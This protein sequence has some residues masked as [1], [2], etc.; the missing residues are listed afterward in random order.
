MVAGSGVGDQVKDISKNFGDFQKLESVLSPLRS[1][2]SFGKDWVMHL[3]QSL[4]SVLLWLCWNQAGGGGGGHET[5]N[6]GGGD[7]GGNQVRGGKGRRM[8][9]ANDDSVK[10]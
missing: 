1:L 8:N 3:D 10:S 5:G 4:S 2:D 7:E 6:Q 9:S